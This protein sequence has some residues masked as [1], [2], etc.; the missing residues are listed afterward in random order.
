[1]EFQKAFVLHSRAFKETSLIIELFTKEAGRKSVIAKGAK[2]PKNNFKALLQPFT[3]MLIQYRGRGELPTLTHAEPEGTHIKL[4]SSSLLSGFYLNEL[5]IRLLHKHDP[6]EYLFDVYEKTLKKMQDDFQEKHLRQ[7]EKEFLKEIGYELPL[8]GDVDGQLLDSKKYYQFMPGS[9]FVP[10]ENDSAKSVFLGRHLL[11]IQNNE[12]D[13]P[14]VL[15][16]AK[17]LTRF[18]LQPLLGDKPLLSRELF[19]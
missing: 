11:A 6:H 16:A 12:H 7:F 3:P 15:L 9:G 8:S 19:R 4:K 1:M 13:D 5:L 17:Y 18:A 2:R 10:C 14:E